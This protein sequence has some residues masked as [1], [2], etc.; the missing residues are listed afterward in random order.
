MILVDF[1]RGSK[2]RTAWLGIFYH[3]VILFFRRR[4]LSRPSPKAMSTKVRNF[5]AI[6]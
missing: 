1:E 2:V 3:D 6:I 5:G 4:V